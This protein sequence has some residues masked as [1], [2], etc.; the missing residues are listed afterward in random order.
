MSRKVPAVI[1]AISLAV[2]VWGTRSPL[3]AAP[4]AIFQGVTLEK[5]KLTS[6][7]PVELIWIEADLSVPGVSLEFTP[8][9]D[10]KPPGKAEILASKPT[11]L[12]PKLGWQVILNGD[13]FAVPEDPKRLPRDGEAIDINGPAIYRGT[14][15]SPAISNSTRYGIFYQL[16]NGTCGVSYSPM[17]K[18]WNAI[19]GFHVILK[20]GAVLAKKDTPLHPRSVVGVNNRTRRIYFLIVDGRRPGQSEGAT[21]VEI[22]EWMK[23]RGATDAL[24]LDGG[25]SSIMAVNTG[26]PPTVRVLNTPV[27]LLNIP[28][29]ERPVAN[30]IGLKAPA[31]QKK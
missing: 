10:P 25:G 27:G 28:G 13:A 1:I 21:E 8:P 6:P 26:S 5:E 4:E 24:N 30:C 2:S 19:G 12:L 11:Q 20:G 17:P 14:P 7:R 22:A 3:H 29:T 16:R 15:F 9:P 23:K 18:A 31:L